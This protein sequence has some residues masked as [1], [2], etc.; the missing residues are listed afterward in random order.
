MSSVTA[1]PIPRTRP[2]PVTRCKWPRTSARRSIW[3]RIRSGR[4][5]TARPPTATPGSG[6]TDRLR[7]RQDD[8]HRHPDG[9]PGGIQLVLRIGLQ[10]HDRQADRAALRQR[11]AADEVQQLPL[12]SLRGPLQGAGPM[13]PRRISLHDVR[14]PDAEVANVERGRP[15]ARADGRHDVDHPQ[16]AGNVVYFKNT[17]AGVPGYPGGAAFVP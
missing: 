9:H 2:T 17:G 5:P 11:R 3:T 14:V 4:G 16:V 13:R 6:R 7:R 10:Q 15:R 8:H 12:W 1:T